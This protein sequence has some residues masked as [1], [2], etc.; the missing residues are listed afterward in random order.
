[1]GRIRKTMQVSTRTVIRTA[2]VAVAALA[3]VTPLPASAVDRLYSA[4]LYAALQPVMTSFSNLAPFA[5]LDLLIAVVLLLW[6]ALA[7]RDLTPKRLRLRGAAAIAARTAVWCAVFYLLFLVVWGLNYRRP[8]MR[9]TLTYDSFAVTPAAAVAAGRLAVVRLN[10]LHDA[11]HTAGW[12]KPD[13]IDANL[14]EHFVRA[15]RDAGIA[16]DVVPGRPKVTILD[17]YFRRAG[18]DGMVDPFFLETLVSG[19]VLAFERPFVV[20]H[21]WAHLA[22]VADEGEANFVAW[23][24]CVRGKPPNAYSG[25][26]F[27][28]SELARAVAPR[29][30]AALAAALGDGPREDLGAIRARAAREVNPRVSAAGWRVYD[31]YLKVNGVEAGAASYDEVVRLVLGVRFPSG[32]TPLSP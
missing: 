9:D 14:A 12:P 32:R 2:I 20:S 22:G 4:H 3:A 1:M 26:L 25:W 17:W 13:D 7:V 18:V 31:S 29:D 28:Y 30:R 8:R 24:S 27:L 5:L 6:I 23:L 15:V 11:A 19:S 10:A 16:R 21:E